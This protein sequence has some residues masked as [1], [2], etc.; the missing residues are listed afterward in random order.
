M[1]MGPHADSEAAGLESRGTNTAAA[2]RLT[3]SLVTPR[4][5]LASRPVDEVI[6]PGVE[7][8]FGVLPGHVAFISALK[9][10]VLVLRNGAEREVFAV[11]PGYLQVSAGGTTRILVQDAQTG[12]DVDVEE[13]RADRAAAEEQLKA[14]TSGD[15]KPGDLASAQ[16][17]LAWAQA[18]LDAAGAGSRKS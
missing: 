16:G 18:R 3:V 15:A 10:G 9:P 4:G 12:G 5:S 13:A 7:G 11:G 14:L 8:E 17:R 6:A 1:A 2:T